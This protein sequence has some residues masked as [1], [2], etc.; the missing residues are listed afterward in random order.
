[1]NENPSKHPCFLRP[2]KRLLDSQIYNDHSQW[3]SNPTLIKLYPALGETLAGLGL[4][5]KEVIHNRVKFPD[6][7]RGCIGVE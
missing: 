6:S 5:K 1:M 3:G 2:A 7:P 4:G